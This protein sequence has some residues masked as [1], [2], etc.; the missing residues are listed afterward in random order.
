VLYH[1]LWTGVLVTDL[2]SALLGAE[3]VVTVSG[4]AR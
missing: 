3:S 1:L 2:A 4:G